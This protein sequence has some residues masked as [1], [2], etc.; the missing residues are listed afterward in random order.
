MPDL[1]TDDQLRELEALAGK[2]TQGRWFAYVLGS[3]GCDVR[4][5]PSVPMPG[6]KRLPTIARCWRLDWESDRANAEFIAAA[7]PKVIQALLNEITLSRQSE[8]HEGRP[9]PDGLVS[10]VREAL[11]KAAEAQG[12]IGRAAQQ[13]TSMQAEALDAAFL[14]EFRAHAPGWLAALCEQVERLTRESAHEREITDKAIIRAEKAEAE[15]ERVRAL[16]I[17]EPIRYA[18]LLAAL[19]GE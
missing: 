18:A 19:D 17:S 2:A 5:E 10:E 14:S 15:I 9:S 1:L 3:E 12:R 6:P 11:A 4:S 13:T 16:L 8:A 7:N